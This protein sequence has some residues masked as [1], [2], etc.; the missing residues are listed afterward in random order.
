MKSMEVSIHRKMDEENVLYMHNGVFIIYLTKEWN[1]VI[2]SSM[3]E[4][5][6]IIL[7]EISQAQENKDHLF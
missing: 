1:P 6:D 2:G 3:H 7:S 5:E 4:L